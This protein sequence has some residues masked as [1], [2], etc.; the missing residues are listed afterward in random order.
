[1]NFINSVQNSMKNSL[2]IWLGFLLLFCYRAFIR[3]FKL[4]NKYIEILAIKKVLLVE[5]RIGLYLESFLSVKNLI[6][7]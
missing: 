6:N 4:L 5:E 2:Q 7:I 3:L 1:M